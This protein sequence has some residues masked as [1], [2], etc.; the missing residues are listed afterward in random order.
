MQA[1]ELIRRFSLLADP[2]APESCR[3]RA[4]VEADGGDADP[5]GGCLLLTLPVLA[6][7][8]DLRPPLT[9]SARQ[10]E[11]DDAAR[12]DE[13]GAGAYALSRNWTAA[14]AYHH[15]L[16]F[17]T[18]ANKDLRT[19]RFSL[20]SA[21]QNRDVLDLHLSWRVSHLSELDFGYQMQSNRASLAAAADSYS[22]RRFVSEADLYHAVTIGITRHFGGSD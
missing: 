9:A 15:E 2:A 19:R 4:D 12:E 8:S 16:L 5:Q 17:P 20:F 21:D 13:D 1:A 7:G 3:W 10:A 22:V 11:A 14:I 6:A 18:A